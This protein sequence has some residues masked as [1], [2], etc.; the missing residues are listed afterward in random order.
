MAGEIFIS[1]RRAD[2]KWARLLHERLQA[3]GVE[4]WYDAHVG[5][6][7]DWRIVTAKALEDSRIFVLL[8][9]QNAAQSS[10]IA[11][12][13]AAA[14]LE[15][16]LVVPVRLENIA[17]KGAFLY[18]LASRNWIN[19]YD[20]TEEKLAELAKGLAHL[21]KTG[22]RDQSALPFEHAAGKSDKQ[23]PH[24]RPVLMAAVA[25]VAIIIAAAVAAWY[26]WPAKHW[27]VESSRPFISTLA[28]EGD[29]AFSPDGKSLAFT[30]S[31]QG[32]RRQIYIRGLAGGDAIKLTNDAY[33]DVSP[34]WS[35][36]GTRLAYIAQ[37]DGEAC[38]IMVSPVPA[39]AAREVSRCAGL[40]RSSVTWRPGTPY[41]YY[42]ER[43]ST[44]PSGAKP[45]TIMRL[46][47]ESG[48]RQP[49]ARRASL[50]NVL[51]A[52]LLCSPDGKRLFFLRDDSF[53]GETI[54]VHDLESGKETDL[55]T[56][57]WAA[58]EAWTPSG[59]WSEDSKAILV[60]ASSGIGSKI[61][62]YP[63]DGG[64]PYEIYTAAVNVR[65]LAAG[66][67]FL[68][69]ETDPTRENLARM[70]ANPGGQPDSIDPANGMSWSPTFAPDGT[71]AFLSNRSGSNAIWRIKPGQP[72]AMFLD[73]GQSIL[74][75]VVYSPDG[76]KLAAVFA[77]KGGA[78][79]RILSQEGAT[80]S[81]FQTL[82]LGLGMPGWTP[83]G[84]GLIVFDVDLLRAVRIDIAQPSHRTPVA[85]RFWDAVT[86]RNDGTFAARLDRPGLWRIDQGETL[87]SDKYPARWDAPI[88]FRGDAVLIPDFNAAAGARILARKLAGGPEQMLGYAPGA[89]VRDIDVASRMA[90][91]PKTGEVIYVASMQGDTNIDLLTMARR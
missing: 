53:E 73:V 2:Q 72:P 41:L 13:L 77:R 28:L 20:N 78:E 37:Q 79:I 5:A 60:S 14:T 17:P 54:V 91:N 83:D 58:S 36:D 18:E 67:G 55:G 7:E 76:T 62:A 32:G 86:I 47:V 1:Y 42:I 45:D 75:R 6:G 48:E 19:A 40:G 23:G 12:E 25:A 56:V 11:K 44:D 35:S 61:I 63:I 9:S 52:Q 84:Q 3:E 64:T 24:R 16:K 85:A 70:G 57:G 82:F 39:G 10:D 31:P 81:T 49:V 89:G 71:L 51:G 27:T 74:F 26:L 21:V 90:V 46:D 30:S 43:F 87:I 65:H 38:R 66:G 88:T 80:L 33:D 29:P 15:K 4:A 50:A 22:A 69:L 68:A 59:A 8:F 34:S